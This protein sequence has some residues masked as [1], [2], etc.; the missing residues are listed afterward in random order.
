[1][2]TGSANSW[3]D[4]H[5]SGYSESEAYAVSDG[6][7][8]G[9][10]IS[11]TTNYGHALLWHGTAQ[12]AADLNPAAYLESD[13]QDVQGNNQ[14]GEGYGS[15]FVSHALLW[16]GT[17]DSA[18]ELDKS[19]FDSSEA[20]SIDGNN[21]VGRGF[22]GGEFHAV[23]WRDF[24]IHSTD[25]HVNGWLSSQA[26]SI[27]GSS[28]AGSAY[29]GNVNHAFVWTNLGENAVDLE[30][31]LDGLTLNGNALNLIGSQAFQVDANGDIVGVGYDASFHNYAIEWSPVPEPASIVVLGFAFL[32][33]VRRR[34]NSMPRAARQRLAPIGC[35]PRPEAQDAD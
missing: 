5:P 22:V 34:D 15:D 28:I 29:D 25:I 2:W 18:T 20:S 11:T 12:S 32:V 16:H 10:G 1:M 31:A 35:A 13:I 14:V 4:L 9:T 6:S 8:G 27:A 19:G 17:A 30:S 7:Q 3:V 26:V 21:I 33:V 23:V 24:G